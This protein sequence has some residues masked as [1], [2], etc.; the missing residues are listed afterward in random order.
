MTP[1]HVHDLG[2]L[3]YGRA[4]TLQER[5]QSA[6]IRGEIED[7]LLLLEHEPVITLG[8]TGKREDILLDDETR[9]ARGIALHET[10]RGG[11]VTLHAPGQLVAYPIFDLR[12]DRCDVRRYVR[13]LGEVMIRLGAEFTVGERRLDLRMQEAPHIGVWGNLDT[14]G[15]FGEAPTRMV[16]LGAIG[17]RLSR[18]VTMHGFAFNATTDLELYGTIVPCGI[19]EHGV[20]SLTSLG[21]RDVPPVRELGLRAARHFGDVFGSTLHHASADQTAALWAFR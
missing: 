17:V 6:R 9:G 21:V 16:K 20:G 12:P 18:W 19:R 1:I 5:L 15:E 4:H 13:D 10:G 2:R 14:P 8:R 3:D 11:E 7:T